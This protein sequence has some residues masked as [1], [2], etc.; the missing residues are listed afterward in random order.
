TAPPSAAAS[1]PSASASASSAVLAAP[2]AAAAEVSDDWLPNETCR[3][4]VVKVTRARKSPLSE[5]PTPAERA[6]LPLAGERLPHAFALPS[7]DGVRVVEHREEPGARS[8]DLAPG[9]ARFLD[10]ACCSIVQSYVR[11]A[12][13]HGRTTPDTPEI[14]VGV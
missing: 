13:A 6:Q 5:R 9:A 4:G 11:F 10:Q 12:R 3:G 8:T 1:S 7:C 2:S 14:D